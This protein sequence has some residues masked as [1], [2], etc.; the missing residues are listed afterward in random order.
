MEGRTVTQ[1]TDAGWY[2]VTMTSREYKAKGK[3]LE[4]GFEA[5][6]EYQG[7]N[8]GAALFVRSNEKAATWEYYFTPEATGFSQGVI[9]EF[10]WGQ[11][12]AWG[13]A[14]SAPPPNLKGL[15]L[16]KGKA[17]KYAHLLQPSK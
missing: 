10:A 14:C 11:E 8:E 6:F 17:G 4:D 9:K 15:S 3:G 5:Q 13:Q 12:Y 16:C 2:K 1:G 7:S